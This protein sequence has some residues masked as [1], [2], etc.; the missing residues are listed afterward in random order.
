MQK[1][2][3]NR[4]MFRQLLARDI[5]AIL[6]TVNAGTWIDMTYLRR[7]LHN[8]LSARHYMNLCTA[9]G[10]C[11]TSFNDRFYRAIQSINDKGYGLTVR[12]DK[13]TNRLFVFSTKFA[14]NY[15]E[16]IADT[17]EDWNTCYKS[18]RGYEANTQLDEVA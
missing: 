1:L 8:T 18:N 10:H 15:V 5:T 9:Q 12:K 3:S 14:D 6:D 16:A 17:F 7:N 11:Y 13:Q 2:I 4:E